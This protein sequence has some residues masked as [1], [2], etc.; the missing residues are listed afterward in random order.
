MG[1]QKTEL[2]KIEFQIEKLKSLKDS[3]TNAN[4]YTAWHDYIMK[5]SMDENFVFSTKLIYMRE[6]LKEINQWYSIDLKRITWEEIKF[7]SANKI[8]K[9]NLFNKMLNFMIENNYIKNMFSSKDMLNYL[10]TPV[11]DRNFV[12]IFSK[13]SPEKWYMY[14]AE[15]SEFSRCLYINGNE[16]MQEI[17]NEFANRSVDMNALRIKNEIFYENFYDSF[18]SNDIAESIND[19]DKFSCDTFELQFDYYKKNGVK[20]D[21]SLLINFYIFLSEKNDCLFKETDSIDNYM[22]LRPNFFNEYSNGARKILYNPYDDVPTIDMWILDFNGYNISGNKFGD[23][24]RKLIDFSV[25]TNDTY[26][27]FVKDWFWKNTS[28]IQGKLSA[29]HYI[30]PFLNYI[31]DLKTKKVFSFYIK[32]NDISSIY[33]IS[34]NEIMAYKFFVDENYNSILAQNTAILSAKSLLEYLQQNNLMEIENSCFYYLKSKPYKPENTAKVIPDD[35]LKLLSDLMKV[36]SEKSYVDK[37][38]YAIFYIA[39]ETEFRL[40]QIVNLKINCVKETAKPNEFVIISKTKTSKGDFTDPSITLYTKQHIDEIIKFTTDIRNECSDLNLKKY[41]FLSN[42]KRKSTY[43][44]HKEKEFNK[45]LKSCCEE[46]K[47]ANYTF[48]NLRDTHI[49]KAE[50]FVLRNN[51][52]D[53]AQLVLTNHTSVNTDNKHYIEK[54]ITE[55]LEL[56]HSTIIGD[57]N[58]NGVIEYKRPELE[59][60]EEILVSNKCGYCQSSFCNEF[61][62]LDCLMCKSFV[63]TVDRI[64]YFK[65][66]IKVMDFKIQ[67]ATI[68]HDKEDFTNIKQLLLNYLKRLYLKKEEFECRNH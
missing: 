50:E 51:L 2:E 22:L 14:S 27:N 64:P 34:L 29:F 67:N 53:T 40:S 63:A 21:L 6:Y 58:I 15:N 56:V 18:K 59:G 61:S 39:L 4:T 19:I 3:F 7:L 25:I 24:S 17:L 1:L 49:T 46:L 43:S 9:W 32:S 48:S 12:E 35:K 37:L 65:E 28:P 30:K 52:S 11:N 13:S 23:E 26:R 31:N 20:K 33:K 62:Y 47:M 68:A 38:N 8:I 66:M 60:N 5:I 42:S 10:C 41:L 54:K 36:K 57:V 45:F 16:F 44:K 55:M